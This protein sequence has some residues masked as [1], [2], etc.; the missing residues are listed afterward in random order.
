MPCRWW[1]GSG[2]SGG[3]LLAVVFLVSDLLLQPLCYVVSPVEFL[4]KGNPKD[5]DSGG[6]SD[7]NTVECQGA[8]VRVSLTG[9]GHCLA[10]VWCECYLPLV[11]PSL[12]IVQIL[13]HLN[14]DCFSI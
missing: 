3:E 14:M 1:I 12:D 4:V 13:L 11:S 10:F 8:V 9:D 5:V 6:F 7:D 2:E